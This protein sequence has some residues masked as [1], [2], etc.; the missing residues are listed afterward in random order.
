[1]R[2][3][4]IILILASPLLAQTTRAIDPPPPVK[5]NLKFPTLGDYEKEIAEKGLLV[6]ND[7]VWLFSPNRK[8]KEAKIIHGYLARAYNELYS[9]VGQHTKYK[10]VVYL[11]PKGW[12]GTGECVIEYDYSNLDFEKSEEWTKYRVPH[13]SGL[14]EEMAHN[15][16]SGTRAQFGWEMVGWSLGAKTSTKVANN[17]IWQ[18]SL[19]DTRKQQADTFA[20]Y[21]QLDFTFPPEIESNLCD[22]IH[23]HLLWQ[24]EQRYGASFWKD[25]FKQIRAA[26]DP[27]EAAGSIAGDDNKRNERYRITVDCFDKLAG[28]NFK[29][30]LESHH[31]ST[32][33]DVKSMHPT[34]PGWNRKFE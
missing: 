29:K 31:I 34:D 13:V 24:C 6:Q 25:L 26:R 2:T 11:S 32:T 28:V 12:G 20:K 17:A 1:M 4:L 9:I 27:L 18:R 23:G 15:F 33:V 16:V 7:F 8:A 5:P 19:Q 30:L 3:L 10:I 22:R 14:I 21:R